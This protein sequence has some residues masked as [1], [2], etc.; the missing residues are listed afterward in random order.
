MTDVRFFTLFFQPAFFY[1]RNMRT[2]VLVVC[3]L[4]SLRLSTRLC[5]CTLFRLHCTELLI[6]MCMSVGGAVFQQLT[7]P[8]S[9]TRTVGSE[10]MSRRRP[11]QLFSAT[12]YV[13]NDRR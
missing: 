2:E 10:E 9:G 13:S 12:P 11:Y 5:L 1:G 4:M 8:S 3:L 7:C 6:A